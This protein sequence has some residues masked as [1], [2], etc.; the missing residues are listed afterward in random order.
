MCRRLNRTITPRQSTISSPIGNAINHGDFGARETSTSK[1]DPDG[2][3]MYRHGDQGDD[4]QAFSHGEPFHVD[5]PACLGVSCRL[6]SAWR[7]M[8]RLTISSR[9]ILVGIG[10]NRSLSMSIICSARSALTTLA[11]CRGMTR[12]DRPPGNRWN[13]RWTTIW[14]CQRLCS[15]RALGSLSEG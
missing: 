4:Q 8:I 9:S 10:R 2:C 6:P 7:S 14:V 11:G 3:K 15:P 12:I 13:I 5:T 1:V